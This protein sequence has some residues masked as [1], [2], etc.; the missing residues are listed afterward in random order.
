LTT[1]KHT[2]AVYI[3]TLLQCGITRSTEN[4]TTVS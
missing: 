4:I 2:S 3:C 1:V